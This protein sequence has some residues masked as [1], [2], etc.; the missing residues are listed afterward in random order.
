MLAFHDKT[1][2]VIPA[3][4]IFFICIIS[5]CLRNGKLAIPHYSKDYIVRYIS[6]IFICILSILWSIN[7]STWL[8]INISI[9]QC[10][11]VGIS[12][13][14][15]EQSEKRIQTTLNAIIIAS[16]ILC[17]RLLVSTPL[18]SWG[19]ER[20]GV[21]I[22]YGNVGVS[23]VL[24]TATI[25]AMFLGQSKKSILLYALAAVFLG[26]SALTGTKKGLIVAVV[27]IFIIIL[28]SSKNPV[29]VLRNTAILL[30][31][32]WAGWYVIM[33]VDI[34]YNAIGKRIVSALLQLTGEGLD[35]S[36]RDRALLMVWGLETFYEHPI[37]GVGVD[38]FRFASNNLINYYAHNN[39]VELLADV[40][41]IGTFIYYYLLFKESIVGLLTKYNSGSYRILAIS[42]LISLLVGDFMSVSYSQETLQLYLAVSFGI[43]SFERGKIK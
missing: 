27:G 29:K 31:L 28:K 21:H 12:L 9:I 26:V 25:I 4:I 23:Y 17:V 7:D 42:I 8:Q 22:G 35:K 14:Y 3:Q 5:E 10:V 36:T 39:Y 32:V 33:N 38:A 41:I 1:F 24:A 2:L 18:S 13:I 16:V 6:F 37:F 40:G 19:S 30:V 34:F 20:V 11:V 15:Y 43:L